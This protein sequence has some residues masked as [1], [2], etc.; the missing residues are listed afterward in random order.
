MVKQFTGGVHKDGIF[1]AASLLKLTGL[2][3]EITVTKAIELH[4]LARR[5]GAVC[6]LRDINLTVSAGKTVVLW[7]DNGAGK[8]TL[9][10]VL[11]TKLRPSRGRGSVFGF[12]LNKEAAQVRKRLAYLNVFG[13]VYG[14]LTA[15][16]NLELAATFYQKPLSREQLVESLAAVGLFEARDKLARTFSSGMKKRLGLARLLLAEAELWL[17]DEPYAALDESG[18]GLIDRLLAQAKESGRT[19]IMASHD[20]ER[21]LNVADSVLHIEQGRLYTGTAAAKAAPLG[22]AH[23]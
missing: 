11:A 1:S 23:G 20:L 2:A 10:K 19:V 6:V 15:L 7:G 16:E 12:D 9:L 4:S 17:L 21:S 14:T 5:Y 3:L 13:G 18:K 22:L 8:T